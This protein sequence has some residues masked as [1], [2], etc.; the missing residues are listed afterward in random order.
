M[1]YHFKNGPKDFR[2]LSFKH[3]AQLIVQ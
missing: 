2:F 3:L 1:L